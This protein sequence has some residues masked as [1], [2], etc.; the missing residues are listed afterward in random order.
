MQN[1]M[2]FVDS[3]ERKLRQH[4]KIIKKLLESNGFKVNDRINERDDPYVFVFNPSNN[5]SFDGVRVYEI[6][7]QIAYRV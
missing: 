2:E 5:L 1:Y 3:K 4:L 7:G 6:G